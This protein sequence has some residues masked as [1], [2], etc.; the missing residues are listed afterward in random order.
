M[1]NIKSDKE[2]DMELRKLS[3]KMAS[4]DREKLAVIERVN[5]IHATR[6]PP[7]QVMPKGNN[8]TTY[9]RT[10]IAEPTKEELKRFREFSRGDRFPRIR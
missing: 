10:D 4:L 8:K 9:P 7:S 6:R 2:I 5:F 3:D 1:S